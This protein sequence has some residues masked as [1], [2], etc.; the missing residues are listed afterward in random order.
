MPKCLNFGGE[1]RDRLPSTRFE[2]EKHLKY[3][4]LVANA[5]E[6]QNVIDLA[7]TVGICKPMTASFAA[8]I[9]PNSA[10]TRHHA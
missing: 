6:I 7:R 2:Q 3:N 5:A 8:R 9:W 10:R 1:G 4:H